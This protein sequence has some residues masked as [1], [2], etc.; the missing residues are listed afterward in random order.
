M[1]KLFLALILVLSIT[2]AVNAQ[3]NGKAIGLRFGNGA[4]VSFNMALGSANRLELDLGL[5]SF[6][7]NSNSGFGLTGIYQWVWALD[8]LAP[9][10]NWYAGVGGTVGS[11]KTNGLGLGVAGQ[12]GLEYNFAIP[13]QLSI[14]YRPAIFLNNSYGSY[15]DARLAIRYRF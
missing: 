1:K 7:N 11:Y 13:L 10:F 6:D 9:G 5:N 3:V 4:E 14:D 2:G 12:I 8:E 15:D